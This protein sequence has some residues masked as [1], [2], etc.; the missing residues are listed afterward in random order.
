MQIKVL[1]VEGNDIVRKGLRALLQGIPDIVITGEAAN[2]VDAIRLISETHPDIILLDINIPVSHGLE[3]MKQIRSRYPKIK[4]LMLSMQDY[5]NHLFDMLKTNAQGYILKN[6][7]KEE[8]IFAIRRI[9]DGCPYLCSEF[10][11]SLFEKLDHYKSTF[12]N[13][14]N[15]ILSDREKDVLHLI[16]DGHTN[17]EIAEKLFTSIRTIET[18]RKRLLEKTGTTNTATLIRYAVKSGLVE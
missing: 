15:V 13:H 2:H 16:A 18:R 8:L 6:T 10:A 12:K 1:F 4:V 7:T 17:A 5:E 9:I 11:I 3:C 14:S